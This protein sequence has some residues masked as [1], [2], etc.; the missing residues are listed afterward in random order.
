MRI[1][2]QLLLLLVHHP[3]GR[4]FL[5]THKRGRILHEIVV[6]LRREVVGDVVPDPRSTRNLRMKVNSTEHL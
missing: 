2:R 1:M 3:N 6:Q 5:L 4:A